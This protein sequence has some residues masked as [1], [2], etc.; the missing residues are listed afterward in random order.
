MRA[1]RRQWTSF[2]K[3]TQQ[4]ERIMRKTL[5]AA[6]ICAL[7]LPPAVSAGEREELL[8]T[9]LTTLN[10]IEALV[11]EGVLSQAA[12]DR[13]IGD[14]KQKAAAEAAAVAAQDTVPAD[15]GTAVRVTYVPEFVRDE[16]RDQVRAQLREDVAQDVLAQAKNEQWGVPGVLPDW[17]NRIKI[18]GDVRVREQLDMYA[19]G[20]AP[21]CDWQA[22]N[23]DGSL[24]TLMNTGEDR[25]KLRAR[26]RLGVDVKV[27]EGIKA[28]VRVTTGNTTNPVS[29]NQTLG[30]YGNRYEAVIDQAY[31]SYD[32][33]NREQY[34][35]LRLTGG[36]MPSPWL[37][38]TDLVWDGDLGFEGVAATLRKN[39]K[40]GDG[41]YAEDESARHLFLTLGAFPLSTAESVAGINQDKWLYGA[42]LGADW[43]FAN[44]SRLEFGVAY[45]DYRNIE[46]RP[47][48]L[49]VDTTRWTAPDY[50]Q[51]GNSVFDLN[52]DGRAPYG[53]LSDF[54]IVNL[55][56]R[57]DIVRF[58]P[59][60]VILS[61]DI[62]RNI[63]FDAPEIRARTGLDAEAEVDAW[64][65]GVTVGWPEIA[66]RRDWQV[67][68]F[69][70]HLERDAVLDAFADSD[71]HLGGT[72]AAGWILGGSYGLADNTWL[73]LKYMS[74]DEIHGLYDD[75]VPDGAPLGIDVLQVDVNAKF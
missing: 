8:R 55:T 7:I 50:M 64:Q 19:D 36:R 24:C 26:L 73:T 74:A 61:A 15:D 47:D 48:P 32:A 3:R 60:H 28:G 53:L 25:D 59:T 72:N 14:A 43:T 68:T 51:K 63:G 29:T 23:E 49:G 34:R 67:F 70:K 27:T 42:Q 20:N 13:L 38:A 6:S 9:Q 66:K 62:A 17:T 65:V 33:L 46:G 41:L 22:S 45:F 18:K 31:L 52:G 4:L 10:L 30:Q 57:Y 35:W 16:I 37:S 71:F 56:G 69:Y 1:N 40:A 44:Q 5:L 11:Q 2:I 39:V 58:A 54:D 75:S 12:A 21:Q